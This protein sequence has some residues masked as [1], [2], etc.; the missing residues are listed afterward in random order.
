MGCIQT[1]ERHIHT[2]HS[3]ADTSSKP[4]D[5]PLPVDNRYTERIW[6]ISKGKNP[7]LVKSGQQRPLT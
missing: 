2:T 5:R 4:I 7:I 3:L 1:P 6:S